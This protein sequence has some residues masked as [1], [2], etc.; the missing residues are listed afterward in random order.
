MNRPIDM[1]FL[2]ARFRL[3]RRWTRVL[4][5]QFGRTWIVWPT[6]RTIAG[7]GRPLSAGGRRLGTSLWIKVNL[8][9]LLQYP[10]KLSK[11]LKVPLVLSAG[12][13]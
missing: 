11:E 3:P 4:I 1:L 8:V 9:L 5:K 6:L 13:L 12:L 10:L 2:A 7:V